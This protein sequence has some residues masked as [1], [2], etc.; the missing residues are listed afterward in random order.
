MNRTTWLAAG[1]AACLGATPAF[2]QQAE[3]AVVGHRY[4]CVIGAA[5]ILSEN[6]AHC[7]AVCRRIATRDPAYRASR[8]AGS[9]FTPRPE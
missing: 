5:A 8:R 3:L 7:G 2:A 1:I 6:D 9:S 4:L